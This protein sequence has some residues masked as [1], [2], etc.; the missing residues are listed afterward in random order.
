[1]NYNQVN[2]NDLL[3]ENNQLQKKVEQLEKELKNYRGNEEKQEQ[4]NKASNSIREKR[5]AFYKKQSEQ[6][7]GA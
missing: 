6:T 7:E 5:K 3:K 1:M 4:I 2:Y